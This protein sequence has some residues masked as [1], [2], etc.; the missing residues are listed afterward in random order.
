MMLKEEL[1]DVALISLKARRLRKRE[2]LA[3]CFPTYPETSN[4]NQ[5]TLKFEHTG[6][7]TYQMLIC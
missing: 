3:N 7:F 4:R 2:G 1:K 5:K 6:Q